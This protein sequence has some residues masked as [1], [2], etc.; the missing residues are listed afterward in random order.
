M[1]EL[2]RR[3]RRQEPYVM[4]GPLIIAVVVVSGSICWILEGD[5]DDDGRWYGEGPLLKKGEASLLPKRPS[6]PP[7]FL[8]ICVRFQHTSQWVHWPGCSASHCTAASDEKHRQAVWNNRANSITFTRSWPPSP[9]WKIREYC[10]L[11]LWV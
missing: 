1:R 11:N 2:R 5:I 3:R 10:K 4:E 9:V 6:P 7:A 8:K